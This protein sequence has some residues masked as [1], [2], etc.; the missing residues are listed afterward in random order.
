M[1]FSV[2][3]IRS[4]F[5]CLC[6]QLILLGSWRRKSSRDLRVQTLDKWRTQTIFTTFM[7]KDTQMSGR[8]YFCAFVTDQK[9]LPGHIIHTY[10][11]TH[12]VLHVLYVSVFPISVYCM[13]ILWG[14]HGWP[15][16]VHPENLYTCWMSCLASLTKSQRW[17][18]CVYCFLINIYIYM[19]MQ[20]IKISRPVAIIGLHFYLF[21]AG[22][23]MYA[24]QNSGWLLLLRVWAPRVS[25]Q[26]C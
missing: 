2:F 24:N 25:A 7:S 23:R 19:Y 13:L 12:Q 10:H 6:Y 1:S 5:C 22:K 8:F 26:S 11:E 4:A 14:S 15:V 16:T 18:C 17:R 9:G 21:H 20:Q 3:V